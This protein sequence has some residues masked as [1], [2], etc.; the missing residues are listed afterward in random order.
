MPQAM[1]LL[2]NEPHHMAVLDAMNENFAPTE[3]GPRD[4][5]VPTQNLIRDRI[6]H[7]HH[8]EPDLSKNVLVFLPTYRILEQQW[9]LLNATRE[10]FQLYVL[11]SSIDMEHSIRT[12]QACPLKQRKVTLN[13]LKS[14]G[15][16]VLPS[17]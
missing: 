8:S 2:G 3:K 1:K 7:L 17:V 4:I 10:P 9:L 15:W 14:L 12:M 11:H 13:L 5:G 6:V 16:L